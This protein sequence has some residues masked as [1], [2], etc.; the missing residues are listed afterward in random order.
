MHPFARAALIMGLVLILASGFLS[1]QLFSA[2]AN[3]TTPPFVTLQGSVTPQLASS[4]FVSHYASAVPMT[5]GVMLVPNQQ[6]KMDDLLKQLYDP[7]SLLY[8]HWLRKG[9]VS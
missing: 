9:A 8:H 4:Q 7:A 6:S 3:A 1:H 2:R 5:V